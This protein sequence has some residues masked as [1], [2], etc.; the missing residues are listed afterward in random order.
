MHILV[1]VFQDMSAGVLQDCMT[2]R[3]QRHDIVSISP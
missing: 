1:V 2:R 3:C